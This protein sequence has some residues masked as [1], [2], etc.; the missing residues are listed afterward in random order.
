MSDTTFPLQILQ[1]RLES[2]DTASFD[3]VTADERPL[4]L[5]TAGAHINVQIPGGPR[6]SYSLVNAPSERRHYRIAVKRESV[7]EDLPGSTTRRASARC[8]RY[9]CR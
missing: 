2:E 8:Y 7:R 1:I 6:R 9:H 4:P 3:L 5:F